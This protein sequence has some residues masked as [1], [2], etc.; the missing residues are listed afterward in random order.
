MDKQEIKN[1]I[2]SCETIIKEYPL[3]VVGC[4]FIGGALIGA[5]VGLLL[6]EE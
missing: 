2:K 6:K 1:R 5:S 3:L 4:V